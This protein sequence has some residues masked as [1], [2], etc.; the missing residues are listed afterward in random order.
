MKKH[1]R[2]LFAAAALAAG[3]SAHAV[4]LMSPTALVPLHASQEVTSLA[5]AGDGSFVAMLQGGETPK[6]TF[7][8][9]DATGVAV[10]EQTPVRIGAGA[11]TGGQ[12]GKAASGDFVTAWNL[13]APDTG[14]AARV[15]AANGTPKTT[16][17]E[18]GIFGGNAALAVAPNGDFVVA[19]TRG[20]GDIE[21]LARPFAAD[22]TPKSDFV[23]VQTDVVA[24]AAVDVAIADNGDFAVAFE[25][26]TPTVEDPLYGQGIYLRRFEANGTPKAAESLAFKDDFAA[27]HDPAIASTADGALMVAWTREAY[28]PGEPEQV[29][30]RCFQADGSPKTDMF[31]LNKYQFGPRSHVD[32]AATN[33]NFVA[34]W[35]ASGQ[36]PVKTST[37]GQRVAA[38]TCA[39]NGSEFIATP[40][41]GYNQ[42]RPQIGTNRAGDAVIA[43]NAAA[44]PTRARLY[45]N[46][47]GKPTVTLVGSTEDIDEGTKVRVFAQL[48]KTLAEPVTVEFTIG[49]TADLGDDFRLGGANLEKLGPQRY[50]LT[51]PAGTR[52]VSFNMNAFVD[53]EDDPG[54]YVTFTLD[55]ASAPTLAPGP[56]IVHATGIF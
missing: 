32:V 41:V 16:P 10:G 8:R 1:G 6:V 44:A 20:G 26:Y 56:G 12:V 50:R 19:W 33:G 46:A 21:I 42:L 29:Q 49:G 47:P 37:I 45:E 36:A 27:S 35:Q 51:F 11:R 48:S 9:F 52:T 3:T 28:G 43:W 15:F 17:I 7:Q 54:E 13:G 31:T 55:P 5:M 38:A 24:I 23:V 40:I 4:E 14:V 30:A 22:G 2:S 25:G 18:V 39:L 34:T 53:A